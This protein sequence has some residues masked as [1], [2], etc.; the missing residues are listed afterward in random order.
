MLLSEEKKKGG[1]YL[2]MLSGLDGLQGTDPVLHLFPVFGA[3]DEPTERSDHLEGE[4]G[5]RAVSD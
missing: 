4:R 5:M 2:V 1:P 3:E